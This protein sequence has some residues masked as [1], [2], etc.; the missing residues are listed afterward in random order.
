[1]EPASKLHTGCPSISTN[2]ITAIFSQ[3]KIP[4]TRR[5]PVPFFFSFFLIGMKAKE[6]QN[7]IAGPISLA[8]NGASHD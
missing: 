8:F 3:V 6:F 7:Q 2:Q 1:M 4:Y 5:A